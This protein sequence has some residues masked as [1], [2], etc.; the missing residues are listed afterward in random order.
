MSEHTQQEPL[1]FQQIHIDAARNS[2]DDFNLFHN[3]HKWERIR[4]NPFGGPIVLGFQLECLVEDRLRLHR[5]ANHEAELIESSRLRFSNYQFTFASVVKPGET[6]EVEIKNSQFKPGD[7]ATLSNRIAIKGAGGIVLFGFKKET[8]TPLFLADADL[9]WLPDL[10]RQT[11]RSYIDGAR[12]FYKRKFMSA[13]NAKNFLSGSLADQSAY[14]DELEER[15]RFPDMYPAGL[16][17]CALLERARHNQHDFENE[18]MVY[19]SHNISM[20]RK[21]VQALRSNDVLHLLVD[22]PTTLTTAK[23]ARHQLHHCFGLLHTGA[24]LF[25]AEIS[26][27]PLAAILKTT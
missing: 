14:F 20:D 15:V 11:D 9:S 5:E 19:T 16:I 23:G 6:V 26:M 2:T 8:Q 4:D 1:T 22:E 3:R 13:G 7:N 25:R 24:I 18:P 21:L 10:N 12:L 27:M 17:S